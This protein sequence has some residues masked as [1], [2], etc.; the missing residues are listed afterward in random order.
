ADAYVNISGANTYPLP[1]GRARPL[2]IPASRYLRSFSKRFR[3]FEPLRLNR[4]LTAM[5]YAAQAGHLFH[6]WWHPEDFSGSPADNL[7][8]LEKVLAEYKVLRQSF[9]MQSLNMA[10]VT[11]L[12]DSRSALS[13]AAD[14]QA[15]SSAMA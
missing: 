15:A 10:E 14:P 6:L 7:A 4:I 5:R 2:N 1:D 13:L 3:L 12:A 9:G 8:F 11:R